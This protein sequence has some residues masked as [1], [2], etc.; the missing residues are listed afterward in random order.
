[1]RYYFTLWVESLL[2]NIKTRLQYRADFVLSIIVSL[3]S[4]C[5]NFLFFLL[6]F[7]YISSAGGM[8][9]NHMLVLIGTAQFVMSVYAFL[10]GNAQDKIFEHVLKGSWDRVRARPVPEMFYVLFGNPDCGN[11]IAIAYAVALIIIGMCRT[12]IEISR[13][14]FYMIGCAIALLSYT[15]LSMFMCAITFYFVRVPAF[16]AL[17]SSFSSYATLPKA[18]YKG[19][20]LVLFVYF[21]PVAVW[22]NMPAEILFDGQVWWRGMAGIVVSLLISFAIL[23]NALASYESAGG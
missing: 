4:Y 11:I 20:L 3:L 23:K 16:A 1:M 21:L 22:G 8:D 10:N 13:L 12:G 15:T 18:M 19:C 17:L 9:W 6:V 5:L 7:R 14:P 2:L